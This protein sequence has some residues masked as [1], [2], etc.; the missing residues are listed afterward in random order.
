[1]LLAVAVLS[2][3][4]LF[5]ESDL[6]WHLFLGRDVWRH[7]ARVVPEGHALPAF[8]RP[9]VVPEWL[10]DVT[11]YGLWQWLGADGLLALL[12]ALAGALASALLRMLRSFAPDGPPAPLILVSAMVLPMGLARLRERPESAALVLLP[13]VIEQARRLPSLANGAALARTGAVLLGLELLWPQLHST[14]VLVPA[15]TAACLIP[16]VV[17][18]PEHGRLGWRAVLLFVLALGLLSSAHGFGIVGQ[19]RD[20]AESDAARHVLDMV[21]TP[22]AAFNPATQLWGPLY[23]GLLSLGILGM[24]VARRVLLQECGLAVLGVLLVATAVRGLMPAGILTAPLALKGATTL[25]AGLPRRGWAL[26]LALGG[27]GAILLLSVERIDARQGPIGARGLRVGAFPVAA[28]RYLADAPPGTPVLASYGAGPLLAFELDG[29][30]RTYVDSR[31]PVYF[32]DTDYAVARDLAAD[33]ASLDR[34][35]RRFG[36]RAAVVERKAEIC[37]ILAASSEWVPVVTEARYTTFLRRDLNP[38]AL[39]LQTVLP[40]GTFDLRPLSCALPL[41]EVESELRSLERV[42]DAAITGFLRA[43]MAIDCSRPVPLAQLSRW[44]PSRLDAMEYPAARDLLWARALLVAGDPAGALRELE[45]L[46]RAGDLAAAELV[47]VQLQGQGDKLRDILGAVALRF[48]DQTPPALRVDLARACLQVGDLEGARFHG[49]RAAVRG[50]PGAAVVL[51]ELL[52]AA[53]DPAVRAEAQAWLDVVAPPP[54]GTSE[55][56]TPGPPSRP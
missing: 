32:D 11:V 31:T 13:L 21:D 10:W 4:R 30:V 56:Q 5:R 45:P 52:Q 36:F 22:W 25:F 14:F 12:L 38:D 17:K 7:G 44:I 29:R 48:G 40:C 20:H 2:T 19:L 39:A 24:V 6:F 42:A 34:G 27:G 46:V 15:I 9:C 28:A 50:A 55:V 41:E 49:V 26:A 33:A 8:T 54:P 23:V 37:P 18:R 35:V 1:M 43:R 3:W 53:P 16:A 51:R 47:S